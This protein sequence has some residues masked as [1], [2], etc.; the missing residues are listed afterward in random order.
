MEQGPKAKAKG[1]EQDGDKAAAI[2]DRKERGVAAGRARAVGTG[3]VR[4]KA[5][6][7][8]AAAPKAVK[9]VPEGGVSSLVK[10]I[11]TGR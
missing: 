8:V 2:P 6:G 1:K 5:V 10:K 11:I 7:K 3:A 4:A 9:R